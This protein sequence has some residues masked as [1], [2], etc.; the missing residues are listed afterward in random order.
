M[1]ISKHALEEM[2]DA[3]IQ[4]VLDGDRK[5]DQQRLEKFMVDCLMKADDLLTYY[6]AHTKRLDHYLDGFNEILRKKL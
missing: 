4:Q 1:F 3:R 6:I 2:I 5:R